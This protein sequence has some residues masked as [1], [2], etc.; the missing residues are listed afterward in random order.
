MGSRLQNFSSDFL[1]SFLIP[2]YAAQFKA[3]RWSILMGNLSD[4]CLPD[5]MLFSQAETALWKQRSKAVQSY[6]LQPC[7][8]ILGR[9][10]FELWKKNNGAADMHILGM[11]CQGEEF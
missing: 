1:Y 2:L 7:A 3:Q 10:V 5:F 6:S 9:L 8:V 4:L 11:E